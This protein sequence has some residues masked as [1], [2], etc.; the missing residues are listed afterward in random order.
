MLNS[1]IISKKDVTKIERATIQVFK[2]N[3]SD[4]ADRVQREVIRDIYRSAYD[5]CQLFMRGHK[6]GVRVKDLSASIKSRVNITLNFRK[7][8]DDIRRKFAQKL[9]VVV[10]FMYKAGKLEF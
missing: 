2:L 4:M 5:G 1:A 7:T 10:L 9:I 3:G 6:A 8:T